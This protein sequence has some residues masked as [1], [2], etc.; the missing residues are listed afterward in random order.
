MA[1]LAQCSLG[2]KSAVSLDTKADNILLLMVAL[3]LEID[4]QTM[5]V[6]QCCCQIR[7][8]TDGLI[9][10]RLLQ[11]QIRGEAMLAW[12]LSKVRIYKPGTFPCANGL[13]STKDF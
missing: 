11:H 4:V 9:Q 13:P 6:V 10:P 3:Q 2:G 1:S 8:Q 5:L 7:D 12:E